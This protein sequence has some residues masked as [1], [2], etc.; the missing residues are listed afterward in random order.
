MCVK[1]FVCNEFNP[2]KRGVLVGEGASSPNLLISD[3]Q[4]PYYQLVS[5]SLK[6]IHPQLPSPPTPLTRSSPLNIVG[7]KNRE[8]LDSPKIEIKW[9]C[10]WKQE[11]N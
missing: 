4:R 8:Q 5:N 6:M 1:Q 2:L 9:P 7:S 11:S 10:T 3:P